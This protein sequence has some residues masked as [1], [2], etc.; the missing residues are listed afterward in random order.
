MLRKIVVIAVLLVVLAT[1]FAS[2]ANLNVNGGS[3]QAGI[4]T[5]LYC[6]EL[7]EVVGWGFEQ[8][9]NSVR[10]VKIG[11]IDSACYGNT[12]F[13]AV[14]DASGTVLATGEVDKLATAEHSIGFDK[15]LAPEDIYKL[16]VWIEGAN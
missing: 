6:D 14:M 7:V 11:N 1:A 15:F 16:K 10:S 5:S 9:D 4:D 3:I 12:M 13:I 8:D 2:A